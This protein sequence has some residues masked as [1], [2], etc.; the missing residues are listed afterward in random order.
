MATVNTLSSTTA[1]KKNFLIRDNHLYL[2]YLQHTTII[3]KYKNEIKPIAASSSVPAESKEIPNQCTQKCPCPLYT[4]IMK[5][6]ILLQN[7]LVSPIL[8][9][10]QQYAKAV[11]GTRIEMLTI[12]QLRLN[13]PFPV[14]EWL[15]INFYPC[16]SLPPWV[17][18][19]FLSEN[20]VNMS[21]HTK[22]AG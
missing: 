11:Y 14:E 8:Q 2:E 19:C 12:R 3:L 1:L 5:A 21:H 6:S 20:M 10:S 9:Q 16:F 13:S 15:H 17:L 7:T 18:H 4:C 22:E